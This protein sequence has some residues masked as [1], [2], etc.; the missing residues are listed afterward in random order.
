MYK[1]PAEFEKHEG[2]WLQF[3]HETKWM[4][5]ELKLEHIWLE[6][7]RL[8]KVNEK[9][10][11]AVYNKKH[12]S[13]VLKMLSYYNIGTNNIT[14]HYI[15]TDDVWARDNG[16]TFVIDDKGKLVIAKWNFNGWG[17]RYEHKLD[18][19]VPYRISRTMSIPILETK[20]TTEGGNI[21][22]NGQGLMITSE[23]ALLNKNRNPRLTK[24]EAEKI[25]KHYLGVKSIIW[26]PGVK[27]ERE[28]ADDTDGHVDTLARF[29]N[30][31]TVVF[32]WTEDKGDPKYD[33]VHRAVKALIDYKKK[34]NADL[35]MVPLHLP[36][37]GVYSTS[38]IGAGGG[39]DKNHRSVRLE[40]SYTNFYIANDL[41]LVPVYAN[42]RDQ[43]T[44]NKLRQLFPDRRVVGINVTELAE[45]G[46]EIHCVTQQVPL[47]R[48]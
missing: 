3:P 21:E 32:S 14:F 31:N 48:G 27:A 35:N 39:D 34:N 10:H 20:I 17:N 38:S 19:E 44:L 15:P 4:L 16:P 13:H 5:Y 30:K 47:I 22:V 43:D 9:V 11:I 18:N 41:V 28:W 8:L 36:E 25:F 1:M 7:I 45:N 46:G 42:A 23:S 33:A 40:A 26:L 29:V 24:E 37:N 2:T 12:Y 6:M